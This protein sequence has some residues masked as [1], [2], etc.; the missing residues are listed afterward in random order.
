MS[1]NQS[2]FLFISNL[3]YF[4]L[5]PLQGVWAGPDLAG[6]S[7]GVQRVSRPSAAADPQ[8]RMGGKSGVSFLV[9]NGESTL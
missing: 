1:A 7:P 9:H 8:C 2:N 6:A 3:R 4:L 5:Q